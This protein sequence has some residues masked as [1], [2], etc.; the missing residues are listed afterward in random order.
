MARPTIDDD[1]EVVVR[2]ELP[3]DIAEYARSQISQL[4]QYLDE[5]VFHTRVRLTHEPNPAVGRP[6]RAQGN[7]TLKGRMVRAQVAGR[8]A[9]E[10][11][12][13]LGDRLK[14]GLERHA[15][16]WQAF[17]GTKPE[18]PTVDASLRTLQDEHEWRHQTPPADRPPYYPRPV[19]D[20]QVIRHKSFT[21]KRVTAD[22]AAWE[23]DQ[24]DYD[25]HLFTDAE[26]ARDAVIF[27][28]GPTGYQ[29]ARVNGG[30]S[31]SKGDTAVT[32]SPQPVPR[33]SLDEARSHL[34]LGGLPFVFFTDRGSD[35][36]ALLYH[37]YDG[38]YGL[39]TP[40]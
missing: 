11:V 25:F 2:G 26:T 3:A 22:E 15:R 18:P 1:L 36:G 40:A 31:P 4:G 21:P 10:A 20:R 13:L 35:R 9:T 7:V 17:R 24:L 8:S 37:R 12:D 39:I 5:P 33:L 32:L 16:N 38:H 30:P 14:R 6:V 34:E 23:M 28:D 27:R 19:E 29:L